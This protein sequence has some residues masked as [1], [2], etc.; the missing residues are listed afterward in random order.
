MGKCLF[1]RK[2]EAHEAPST[3]T[4]FTI[5]CDIYNEYVLCTFSVPKKMTFEELIAAGYVNST[6]V[7]PNGNPMTL[8]LNNS[9]V[10]FSY[11][12]GSGPVY[13]N[14]V[15]M[16]VLLPADTPLNGALY[17]GKPKIYY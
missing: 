8:K 16:V 4:K 3:S 6:N 10:W 9:N 12:G 15:D 7:D 2:C 11:Y 1:M 17:Y 5:G 14:A 13:N